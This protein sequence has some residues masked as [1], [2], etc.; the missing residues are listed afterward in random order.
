MHE[1]SEATCIPG[2]RLV[3]TE[4]D[5]EERQ[6]P[7]KGEGRVIQPILLNIK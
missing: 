1:R 2:Q 3:L 6:E 7:R 5:L 4:T